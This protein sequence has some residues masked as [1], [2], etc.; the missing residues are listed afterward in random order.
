MSETAK[1]VD[2][3]LR[4]REKNGLLDGSLS[5][6]KVCLKKTVLYIFF[7]FFFWLCSSAQTRKAAIAKIAESIG[8]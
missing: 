5:K 7:A 1:H 6:K 8:L 2:M 3:I 4:D